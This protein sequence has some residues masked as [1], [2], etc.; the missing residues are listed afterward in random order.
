[1]LAAGTG[2]SILNDSIGQN[3][4]IAQ[5]YH[6]TDPHSEKLKIT[7]VKAIQTYPNGTG[8]GIVKVE[9]NEPGLY[10]IGCATGIRR[11]K[12]LTAAIDEYLAPLLKGKDPDNIEHIW[13]TTN[14]GTYWHNGPFL[15][16]AL[17]VWIKLSGTS[18]LSEPTCPPTNS[19]GGKAD[20]RWIPT[21][22]PE[23]RIS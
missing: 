17:G 15:N 13:Q 7:K 11:Y 21:A 19:L 12:T 23:E 9:T 20:S 2:A 14:L 5:R 10:G 6:A 1:M 8:F 16:T 22:M 18:R 4:A 3:D